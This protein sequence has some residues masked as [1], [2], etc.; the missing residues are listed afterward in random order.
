[1]FNAP[2]L[3]NQVNGGY[4]EY[5]GSNTPQIFHKPAG[6]NFIN[7]F[8]IGAGGGGGGGSTNITGTV[9]GGGGG[10]GSGGI[11]RATI[12]ALLLPD[13]M[14]V[15]TGVGGAGGAAGA[16]GV[17]GGVGGRTLIQASSAAN[18]RIILLSGNNDAGGGVGGS[19]SAGTG[20][21]AGTAFTTSPFSYLAT[22]VASAGL[23]GTAAG[24]VT[25][26]TGV[27]QTIGSV[28]HMILGGL[29]GGTTPA[30]NTDF[31]GGAHSGGQGYPTIAGGTAAGGRGQDGIRLEKPLVCFGGTG[32]GTGGAG[33]AGAG[34]NGIFG[35][36][37]GGGGGGITG[38]AGGRGGDG[39]ALISWF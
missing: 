3:P 18:T 39:Y 33:A 35:S 37:G 4:V 28:T 26:A 12:P 21:A 31:A 1:M 30:A 32:G 38:G 7:F 2:F 9:R 34:G 15:I 29:G 27:N 17:T 13:T 5:F 8:L 25:G 16:T 22:I 24:A 19:T 10:G 6:A 14:Y 20:G 23:I 11:V 36:G